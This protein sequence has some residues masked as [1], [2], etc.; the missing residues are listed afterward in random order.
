M[1][2]GHI[3]SFGP[4]WHIY[5]L[6]SKFHLFIHTSRINVTKILCESVCMRH[7]IL[8]LKIKDSIPSRDERATSKT[9][10]KIGQN[11]V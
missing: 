3:N 5:F 9:T 2:M 11:I 10:S 4:K 6:L 7:G 1:I 8:L